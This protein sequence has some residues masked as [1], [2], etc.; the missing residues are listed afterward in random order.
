MKTIVGALV[1]TTLAL[2]TAEPP[3]AAAKQAPDAEATFEWSMPSRFGSAEDERGRIV[4]TQPYE[5]RRGPWP[6]FLRVTGAACADGAVHRWRSGRHLLEPDRLGP[7]RYVIRFAREGPRRVHL[8]TTVGKKHLIGSRK[9]V[10]QDWLIVA[11]GDSVAAG[12][13]APDVFDSG[14]AV[15]QS[16][17]CHRSARAAVAQAAKRIEDDDRHSSVTFVHLACSGATVPVGLLGPYAGVEPPDSEPLLEPQVPILN[18]IGAVRPVDAVLLSVGANDVHFGDMARFCALPSRDC[19]DQPLPRGFG[20]DGVRTLG[21]TVEDSL[22]GLGRLYERLVGR[23]SR[24][25]PASRVHIV[26]YFDP[27]RDARGATCERILV[28]IGAHELE[29]AQSRVLAPLN[30]AIARAADEHGWT[31]VGG[32]EQ[33]FRNHGYCARE[34]KW[35]TTLRRSAEGLGG[36]LRGRFLGTLHPNPAGYEATSTLISASL[37]RDFYPGREFPSRPL[38]GPAEADDSDGAGTAVGA[39][40]SAIAISILLGPATLVAALA[41]L[42]WAGIGKLLWLGRDSVSLILLGGAAGVVILV[43]PR[44]KASLAL[45]PFATLARTF[46]PL[47]LPLFVVLAAGTSDFSL[48]V[49]LPIGAA[50]LVLAWKLIVRPEANKSQE[51]EKADPRWGRQLPLV[52]RIALHSAVLLG[53][54]LVAVLGSKWGGL[55]NPYF[56]AIGGFASGVLLLAVVLWIFAF[57]LR[58]ISFATTTLRIL[59]AC[60]I[61]L[62]L[63]VLAAGAGVVPGS[64]VVGDDWL[65]QAGILA[66]VALALLAID[67]VLGVIDDEERKPVT[68]RWKRTAS[69]FG[70]LGFSAAVVATVALAGATAYGLIETDKRGR[71]LNPPQNETADAKALAP[72]AAADEDDFELARKYAPVLVFSEGE[73]WAPIRVDSYVRAAT[74]SG[75][76]GPARE[77]FEAGGKLPES[78]PEFGESSCYELSIGCKTGDLECARGE[79]RDPDRLYR[80]GAVYVRVLRKGEIPPEEP[81]GAFAE[82]G[83]YRDP[84]EL[85]IQ[86]WYFYPYNEWRTPVFAGLLVQRHEADWEAVTIG[87]GPDRRPLFVANSAHCSGSWLPWGE[88]EASTRLPGPRTHPLVAVAEGSHANYPDAEEKRSPDWASCAGAPAGVTTAVSYASNI[89]D[90]TGF[91]WLWYPPADGWIR[92]TPTEP[93]MSFPGTWGADDRTTL[94]NFVTHELHEGKAPKTPS[95]QP[96]WQEPVTAIFCSRFKPKKCTRPER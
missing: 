19:F 11:I 90:E 44:K 77:D 52:L 24:R 38:P 70:D 68:G 46:R 34:Q 79:H 87:F 6:V 78:C 35:V 65:L 80:D 67:A 16:V 64:D 60:L 61:G 75:P 29:Q 84:L 5:V 71:P 2:G 51:E 49:Q 95:L 72:G 31:R 66:A 27:T 9:I 21:Q 28:S 88:V 43:D 63:L 37:E 48:V 42:A 18:R 15:W 33:L 45:K 41:G 20:G 54:A 8:D 83:P 13:G 50:L 10:V 47:L 26:E 55:A 17:R 7:C 40:L 1:L 57:A 4:E 91:G 14:H 69:F 56:E 3:V 85:L 25:I 39:F 12:E 86:Y 62:A 73:R 58:L 22:R 36:R 92:A 30:A 32:V 23:I 89:R 82:R 81:P 53:V 76:P 93:P 74:L 96:L 94:R 59:L